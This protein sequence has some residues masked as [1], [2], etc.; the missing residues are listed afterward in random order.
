MEINWTWGQAW[1]ITYMSV[2]LVLAILVMLAVVTWLI[3]FI[4]GRK[5][6]TANKTV[7]EHQ[8]TPPEQ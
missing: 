5:A 1:Q 4:G 2:G 8:G 3:G 6:R 7:P